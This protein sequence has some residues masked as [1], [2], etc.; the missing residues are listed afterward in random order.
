M[1]S[2]VSW[3]TTARGVLTSG[4]E[5]TMSEPRISELL[6]ELHRKLEH[7]ERLG[8]ADRTRLRELAAEIE[9]LPH[10][11]AEGADAQPRPG[12]ARLK[13]PFFNSEGP[14]PDIPRTLA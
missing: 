4:A 9:A 5:G 10:A 13:E 12:R 6:A 2:P 3:R 7:D 1:G 8:E 11:R 14:P